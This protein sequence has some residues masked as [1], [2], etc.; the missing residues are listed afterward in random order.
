M[1]LLK[2]HIETK[3]I[4]KHFFVYIVYTRRALRSTTQY[5][6]CISL[7]FYHQIIICYL[8]VTEAGGSSGH[9]VSSISSINILSTPAIQQSWAHVGTP[10]RTRYN[11]REDLIS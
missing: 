10:F 1:Y 7:I 3:P 9:S 4:I 2:L 8:D 6:F 11:L 5:Q